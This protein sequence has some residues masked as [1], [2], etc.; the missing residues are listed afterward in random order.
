LISLI[1][2]LVSSHIMTVMTATQF[3]VCD[4]EMHRTQSEFEDQLVFKVF[5][6]QFVNFYSS[7]I[8]IGFFKGKSVLS[9]LVYL[10]LLVL[11]VL[12]LSVLVIVAFLNTSLTHV[13]SAVA[14]SGPLPFSRLMCHSVTLRNIGD[15]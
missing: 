2:V 7:I 1:A 4:V 10:Y 11:A 15:V 8:Y 12:V 13:S 9:G 5:I 14:S 3:V 6:F